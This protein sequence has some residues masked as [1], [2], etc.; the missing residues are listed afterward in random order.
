[1][2]DKVFPLDVLP[3]PLIKAMWAKDLDQME[4]LG[5][6]EVVPEDFALCE[7]VCPSKQELQKMASEAIDLLQKEMN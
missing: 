5:A 6:Y 4:Q 2:Y 1:L 7:V 3:M